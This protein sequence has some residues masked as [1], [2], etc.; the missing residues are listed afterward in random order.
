V[1]VRFLLDTHVLLWLIGDPDRLPDAVR[2][3]LADP[4]NELHVSAISAF[5][6]ATKTRSGRLDPRGLLEGWSARVADIGAEELPLRSNHALHAGSMRWHHRDPFDRVLVAQ[7]S[8]EAMTL[9]TVDRALATL[10][11]PSVLTW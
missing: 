5:E 7:A 2:A 11:V 1:G 8:I 4:E 3:T 10:P 6:V 9:V